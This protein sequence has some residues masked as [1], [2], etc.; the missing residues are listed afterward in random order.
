MKDLDFKVGISGLKLGKHTFDWK[1]DESFFEELNPNLLEKAQLQVDVIL[2]RSET[3]IEAKTYIIGEVTLA[4]D[5]SLEPFQEP[6]SIEEQVFFK[7]GEEPQELSETVQ[8]IAHNEEELDF[9]HLV[10]ELVAVA[11]PMKRLHPNYREEDEDEEWIYTVE[12]EAEGDGEEAG[13]EIADPR[14][15]ALKQLNFG[16]SDSENK[17]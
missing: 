10:Y 9:A 13:K 7:Y 4:C 6:L 12:D 14:W 5:R 11:I 3:M 16:N 17:E 15:A 2:S 1:I 8:I